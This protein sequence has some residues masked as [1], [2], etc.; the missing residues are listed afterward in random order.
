MI[1]YRLASDCSVYEAYIL[2]VHRPFEFVL[3]KFLE[4]RDE[5]ANSSVFC[6]FIQSIDIEM[7][8]NESALEF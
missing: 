1:L 3:I 2:L 7:L 6:H 8:S 4:L 5:R